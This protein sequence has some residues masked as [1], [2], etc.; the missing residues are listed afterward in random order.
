MKYSIDSLSKTLE[1]IRLEPESHT[2][3]AKRR[4]A[5][6]ALYLCIMLTKE[7][8][9]PDDQI[10]ATADGRTLYVR[11]DLGRDLDI[12]DKPDRWNRETAKIE[13]D[14]WNHGSLPKD[15]VTPIYWRDFYG[16]QI[17]RLMARVAG[18]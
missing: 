2:K 6:R 5:A 10:L 4:N 9:P 7:N 12:G 8:D 17:A 13:S 16:Q 3:D 14:R 18:A 11:P 15:H 1:S